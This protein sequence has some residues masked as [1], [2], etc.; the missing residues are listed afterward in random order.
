MATIHLGAS[1]VFSFF[2]SMNLYNRGLLDDLENGRSRKDFSAFSSTVFSLSGGAASEKKTSPP[3][4]AMKETIP[5]KAYSADKV[6][7]QPKDTP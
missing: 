1:K 7:R 3:S 2:P 4:R 5:W 6:R